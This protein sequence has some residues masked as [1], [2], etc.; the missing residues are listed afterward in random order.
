MHATK[1]EGV[2][3][4]VSGSISTGQWTALGLMNFISVSTKRKS[5]QYHLQHIAGGHCGRIK[6]HHSSDKTV[7]VSCLRKGS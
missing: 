5:L 1:K 4:D 6:S 2:R 7:T 3:L